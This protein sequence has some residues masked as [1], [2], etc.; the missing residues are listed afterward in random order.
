MERGNYS[1][2]IRTAVEMVEGKNTLAFPQKTVAE[3]HEVLAQS[4]F[5]MDDPECVARY[6]RALQAWERV[7]AAEYDIARVAGNLGWVLVIYENDLSRAEQLYRRAIR[8]Q[9]RLGGAEHPSLVKS[10]HWLLDLLDQECR[11]I[12]AQGELERLVRIYAR[13]PADARAPFYV[14]RFRAQLARRRG[15][16]MYA[17]ALMSEAITMLDEGELW[18]GESAVGFKVPAYDFLASMARDSG[19]Y[20]KSLQ[21]TEAEFLLARD[22][23]RGLDF[24]VLDLYFAYDAARDGRIGA[25]AEKYDVRSVAAGAELFR[26]VLPPVESCAPELGPRPRGWLHRGVEG[27]ERV[28]RCFAD[29][30]GLG[31]SRVQIQVLMRIQN[32]TVVAAKAAGLNAETAAL[33]CAARSVVGITMEG[34]QDFNFLSVYWSNH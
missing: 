2:A 28:D 9:E 16:L 14:N 10:V 4:T 26:S 5:R 18:S 3:L 32:R 27:D 29:Q 23:H 22:D 24:P 13:H 7:P 30:A 12:E 6:E 21:F 11:T 20:D 1:E 19:Q 31:P 34:P 33:D 17:M 15:Q 8:I 25:H